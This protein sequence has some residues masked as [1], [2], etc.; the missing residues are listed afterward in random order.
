MTAKSGQDRVGTRFP[1][2]T[3]VVCLGCAKE[4]PYDWEQMKV[5]WEPLNTNVHLS[6]L[7]NMP[8][9]HAEVT[10]MLFRLWHAFNKAKPRAA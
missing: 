5:I 7:P 1:T 8:P 6:H 9:P 2:G 10:D 4:F 3:Y